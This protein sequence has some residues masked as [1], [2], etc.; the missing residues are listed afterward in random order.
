MTREVRRPAEGIT[1][2]D[3]GRVRSYGPSVAVTLTGVG[4]PFPTLV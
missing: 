3:A 4:R 1:Q 2:P